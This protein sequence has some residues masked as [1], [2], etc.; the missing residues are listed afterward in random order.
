MND[1]SEDLKARFLREVEQ[2]EEWARHQAA[3]HAEKNEAPA[4][5]WSRVVFV[6]EPEVEGDSL[7]GANVRSVEDY[8]DRFVQLVQ[9]GRSD[10]I[11]FNTDGVC[12]DALVIVVEHGWSYEPG[13]CA[14]EHVQVMLCGPKCMT[15]FTRYPPLT[16]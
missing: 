12:G 3:D 11:N 13:G 9:E 4:V 10:W 14:P 16:V 5:S 1:R 7:E 15:G 8:A 2:A 6:E